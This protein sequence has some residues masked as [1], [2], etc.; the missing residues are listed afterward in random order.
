MTGVAIRELL[1]IFDVIFFHKFFPSF[2]G[3]ME[4]HG[5]AS[6]LLRPIGLEYS[7]FG[8]DKVLRMAVALQAPGHM[9]RILLIHERHAIDGTVASCAGHALSHMDAVIE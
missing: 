7:L 3:V 9:Q 1:R 5:F 8:A 2:G 6:A 4:F